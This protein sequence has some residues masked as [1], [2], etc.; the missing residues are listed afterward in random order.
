VSRDGRWAVVSLQG[1]YDSSEARPDPN[2]LKTGL[3][4]GFSD[5]MLVN[6]R[7]GARAF[8]YRGTNA[9]AGQPYEVQPTISPDGRW[10]LLKDAR[11]KRV[12][13][14]EI[15]PEALEKFLG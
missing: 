5:V 13:M 14:L 12:L 9:T 8:L 6:M 4:Y 11:E 7:S 1:V 3:G 2:W 15:D 10:V